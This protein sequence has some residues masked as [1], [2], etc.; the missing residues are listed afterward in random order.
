MYKVHSPDADFNENSSD[1]LDFYEDELED[2]N[3]N[4]DIGDPSAFITQVDKLLANWEIIHFV[5]EKL[6]DHLHYIFEVNY[7]IPQINFI[8]LLLHPLVEEFNT[9]DEMI[10][11]AE[12]NSNMKKTITFFTRYK[13]DTDSIPIGNKIL[14]LLYS[15]LKQ[16]PLNDFNEARYYL[17]EILLVMR[18]EI[19]TAD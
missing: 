19:Y 3:N 8:L 17:K 1:S 11:V 9:N 16:L 6:K 2:S 15:L 10:N 4:I 13:S 14:I 18:D 5:Y 12:F 7:P